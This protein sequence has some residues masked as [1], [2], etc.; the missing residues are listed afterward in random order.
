MSLKDQVRHKFEDAKRAGNR[1]TKNLLSVILGDISTAEA[2][3]G[4]DIADADVEKML[5]KLVESDTE[6]ISQMK[7][8]GRGD[9]PQVAVLERE[10]VFV[11][12]LVP[13]TLD[14]TAI[15][16]ALEPVRADIVTAKSDGQATGVA[17]KHL[18]SL[19]LNAQGQDVSAVVKLFRTEKA[20][21]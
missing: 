4:K 15:A 11:K 21:T 13:Q 7:A 6:T 16:K 1:E 5:R 17:M 20:P 8:H 19:A 9:D 18:K 10:I 14:T 2:R 12:S 3:S